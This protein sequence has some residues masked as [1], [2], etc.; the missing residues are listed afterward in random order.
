[1]LGI[2]PFPQA[3]GSHKRVIRKEATQSDLCSKRFA[4]LEIG[5]QVVITGS[6]RETIAVNRV[7]NKSTRVVI[8]E[9]EEWKVQEVSCTRPLLRCRV[10]RKEEMEDN[11]QV[12]C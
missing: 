9:M 1:M 8:V 6:F 4:N 12:S 2:Q 7:R 5:L 11:P 10:H 3:M